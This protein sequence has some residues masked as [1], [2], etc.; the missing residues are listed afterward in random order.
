[1][2]SAICGVNTIKVQLLNRAC[3]AFV[4]VETSIQAISRS[5]HALRRTSH[6]CEYG[7]W[8]GG[9]E[10]DGTCD[11]DTYWRSDLHRVLI[12]SGEDELPPVFHFE[13]SNTRADVWFWP[14][15]WMGRRGGKERW[16]VAKVSE[17]L[18]VSSRHEFPNSC[19]N[20]QHG[21]IIQSQSPQV[22]RTKI[23]ALWDARVQT[24]KRK[25]WL[26]QQLCWRPILQD[27]PFIFWSI[28]NVMANG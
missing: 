27:Q 11:V 1:M 17:R 19:T 25:Q 18:R 22:K 3:S 26:A 10:R 5:R 23:Q 13:L 16:E 14:H 2:S 8:L 9:V 28:D 20:W 12:G 15:V 6:C 24:S 7:C 21:W 4:R